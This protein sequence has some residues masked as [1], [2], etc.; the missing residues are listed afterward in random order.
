MQLSGSAYVA[1]RFGAVIEFKKCH[2]A[3]GLIAKFNQEHR[4]QLVTPD[5]VV[6]NA[7][8]PLPNSP[9]PLLAVFL[10]GGRLSIPDSMVGDL[11]HFLE[12]ENVK[13]D[14]YEVK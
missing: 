3:P 5:R 4:N 11:V 6:K 13:R 10:Q 8:R 14:Q 7:P 1:P 12:E 2:N 9:E